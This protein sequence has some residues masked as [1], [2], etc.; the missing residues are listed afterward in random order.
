M[1]SIVEFTCRSC[2]FTTEHLRVG[3]GKEGRTRFWGGLGVCPACKRLSVVDLSAKLDMHR[4][5]EC[6]GQLTLLEGLAQDIPCPECSKTL[7][8]TNLGV[9]N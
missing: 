4:C 5:K 6:Q 2:G 1:G 9:W 7:R 8:S 3:W